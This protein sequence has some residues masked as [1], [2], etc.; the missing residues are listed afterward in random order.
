MFYL[1]Q[2]ARGEIVADFVRRPA[3]VASSDVD[4]AQIQ[5]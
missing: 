4:P 3:A 2:V 1:S 5:H